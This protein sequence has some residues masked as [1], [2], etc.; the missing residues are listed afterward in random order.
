[1]LIQ[2]RV[3]DCSV[4]T[5]VLWSFSYVTALD[6]SKLLFFIQTGII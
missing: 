6:P 2:S 4:I 5:D 3:T 1:M